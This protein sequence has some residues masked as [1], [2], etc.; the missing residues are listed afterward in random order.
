MTKNQQHSE[1]LLRRFW[2]WLGLALEGSADSAMRLQRRIP[3][4]W[5]LWL[6]IYSTHTSKTL[7]WRGSSSDTLSE[8]SDKN[9][10]NLNKGVQKMFDHF[11]PDVKK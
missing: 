4:R 9:I 2:R 10:K 8:K 1:Y 7:L 11:P 3:T 6:S 5:A